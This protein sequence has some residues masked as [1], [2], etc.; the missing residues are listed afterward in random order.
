MLLAHDNEERKTVMRNMPRTSSIAI[1]MI[2]AGLFGTFAAG[3]SIF[4]L[5]NPQIGGRNIEDD[6]LWVRMAPALY[7]APPVFPAVLLNGVIYAAVT[8]LFILVHSL[9]IRRYRPLLKQRLRS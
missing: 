9:F 1:L 8:F 5:G 7:I 6:L 2:I 3:L 4:A